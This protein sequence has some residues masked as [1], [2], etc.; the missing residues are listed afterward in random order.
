MTDNRFLN[1]EHAKT[2]YAHALE[3]AHKEFPLKKEYPNRPESCDHDF[4]F[5]VF[6]D[7]GEW[8]IVRCQKCGEERV[9]PC[10]FDDDYS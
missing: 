5:V 1:T 10:S 2:E 3:Q 9:A 4:N 8:D 7:G 6:C